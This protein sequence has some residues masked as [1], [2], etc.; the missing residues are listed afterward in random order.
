MS[1]VERRHVVA[2]IEYLRRTPGTWPSHSAIWSPYG[3]SH[4][5][6]SNTPA[7]SSGITSRQSPQIISTSESPSAP[8]AHEAPFG[9][10]ASLAVMVSRVPCTL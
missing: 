6:A 4:T 3:G 7:G 2:R 5:H 9:R 8:L 1:N 10:L